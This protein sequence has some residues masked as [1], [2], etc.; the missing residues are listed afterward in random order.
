MSRDG[1]PLPASS[2][3]KS[4]ADRLV[5]VVATVGSGLLA[6]LL[7]QDVNFDQ[8]H[9]HV[10]LGWSI[11]AGRLGQDVAPAGS[12][13]Y[14]NPFLHV[15]S[16]LGIA[17]LPPRVFGFALGAVH[18]LNAYL[19]YRLARHVLRGRPGARAH[20]AIAGVVAICGPS[21]VALVGTT[22]GDNLLSVP[23]LAAFLLAA[24]AID[25][26]PRS[27]RR[28]LFAAGLLAGAAAGLKLTFA[29]F[30]LG[31]AAASMAIGAFRRS[32]EAPLAVASGG[33][34]GALLA[35]GY[36]AWQMWSR[37]SNPIFPV[38]NALF[39]VGFDG[40][41]TL[42]PDGR[43]ASERWADVLVAPIEIALGL[44]DHLQEVPFRDVRCLL[45]VALIGAAL[46]VAPR[47]VAAAWPTAAAL[48]VRGFRMS[49]G[50]RTL[51]SRCWCVFRWPG[52]VVIRMAFRGSR[53]ARRLRA[54]IEIDR[55]VLT[56]VIGWLTAYVLWSRVFHYYRY[57]TAGEFLAPVVIAGLLVVLAPARFPVLWPLAA[58]TMLVSST[59]GSWGRLP[60]RDEPMTVRYGAGAR[61]P[62]PAAV[63]VDG[64][65]LSYVLPFL[66]EGSRFF[67]IGMGSPALDRLVAREIERYP[68]P[69][70]RLVQP[71]RDPSDLA[72]LGL[73]DAGPCG[74]LRTSGRGRLLLCPLARAPRA[75]R[76]IG[77]GAE[78]ATSTSPEP[79]PPRAAPRAGRP[80]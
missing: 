78:P 77:G 32:G 44:T 13:S 28:A 59:T 36:W 54:R 67:G 18:G 73:A 48:R 70:L 5:L 27:A 19:V 8:L 15:P 56:L 30:A 14:L 75:T 40:T 52:G 20:A 51:R 35:G 41:T 37:F 62:G 46:V 12:G 71:E 39:P 22:F 55:V 45:A 29:P 33:A 58:A 64:P 7:G 79:G 42:T 34:A 53:P 38:A 65:G 76:D 66:P 17:H 21:A 23:V 72:W 3:T 57:F 47:L 4:L 69:F 25:G 61:P 60:W 2:P 74:V 68:G 24:Q 1:K 80:D 9:Y 49:I 16:Y 6:L 11:L 26:P 63:I 31:L 43:W 50:A 10:Y